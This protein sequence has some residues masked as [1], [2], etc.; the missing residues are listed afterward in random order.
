[1]R[2]DTETDVPGECRRQAADEL[3]K[4]IQR[5]FEILQ[6]SGR[7]S[8]ECITFAQNVYR[9]Q[10]SKLTGDYCLLVLMWRYNTIVDSLRGLQKCSDITLS[11]AASPWM[12]MPRVAVGIKRHNQQRFGKSVADQAIVAG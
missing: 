12:R 1:L 4:R 7:C 10:T 2:A 9:D 8:N 11:L 5:A 3:R 6:R